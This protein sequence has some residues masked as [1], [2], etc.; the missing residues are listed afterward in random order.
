M[1]AGR[2]ATRAFFN[3]DDMD[4][5]FGNLLGGFIGAPAGQGQ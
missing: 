1:C 2:R 5:G 3:F 4:F